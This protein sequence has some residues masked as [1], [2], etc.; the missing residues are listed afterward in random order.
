MGSNYNATQLL[1]LKMILRVIY[2]EQ[3]KTVLNVCKMNLETLCFKQIIVAS[4]KFRIYKLFHE[5]Y[6]WFK[7]SSVH[8]SPRFVRMNNVTHRN[9]PTFTIF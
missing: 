4:R 5:V 2:K 6:K 3:D 7:F 9:K 1:Q 8:A